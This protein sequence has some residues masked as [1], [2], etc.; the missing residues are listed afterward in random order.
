MKNEV[1]TL[2]SHLRNVCDPS[3]APVPSKGARII[4][5]NSESY[6]SEEISVFDS[7]ST[8]S[9]E[10]NREQNYRTS[11]NRKGS[12]FPLPHVREA[13]LINCSQV[14]NT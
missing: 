5:D 2:A 14:A 10:S 1:E 7:E 6:D 12:S 9:I 13:K 4:D 3:T 11:D 8:F